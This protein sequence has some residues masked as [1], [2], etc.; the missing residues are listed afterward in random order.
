MGKQEGQAVTMLPHRRSL[1]LLFALDRSES[2]V[3][4]WRAF[5]RMQLAEVTEGISYRY[6][7]DN[8]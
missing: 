5:A 8:Q 2:I 4:K 7:R 1:S 6:W 3:S